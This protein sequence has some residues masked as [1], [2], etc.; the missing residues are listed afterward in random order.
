MNGGG[1]GRRDSGGTSPGG[2]SMVRVYRLDGT[3]EWCSPTDEPERP[4]GCFDEV[5]WQLDSDPYAELP[6]RG[7]RAHRLISARDHEAERCL[8]L[9]RP[10]ERCPVWWRDVRLTP[11][12]REVAELASVGATAIQ[13]AAHLSISPHTVRQH[14][15]A[16]YRALG[17]ANRVELAAALEHI[18]PT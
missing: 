6:E 16:V 13:M 9:R 12:Q 10:M 4:L 8:V 17:V 3:L 18:V 14:L 7:I 2:R 1:G 5:R 11:R 15:K